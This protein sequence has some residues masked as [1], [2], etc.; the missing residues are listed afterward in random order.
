[1]KKIVLLIIL[2]II[3]PSAVVGK[4]RILSF[5]DLIKASEIIVIAKMTAKS[6]FE[7][8]WGPQMKNTLVLERCLK[9][10]WAKDTPLTFLTDER[11]DSGCDDTVGSPE[12]GARLVLFF[13]KAADGSLMIVNSLQGMWLL[14]SGTARPI[15]MGTTYT[16]EAIEKEVLNNM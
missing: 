1:M 16:L 10:D 9:G 15:G 12:I 3:L 11:K 8:K 14:E 7:G 4:I 6:P 13:K 5:P 2:S